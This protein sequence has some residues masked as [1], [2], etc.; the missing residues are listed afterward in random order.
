MEQCLVALL[1]F[2]NIVAAKTSSL[3]KKNTKTG[4]NRTNIPYTTHIHP[5]GL[6][7]LCFLFAIWSNAVYVC[8]SIC[9]ENIYGQTM[10][11]NK[12]HQWPW[13]AHKKNEYYYY[14]YSRNWN[15]KMKRRN[16]VCSA[17]ASYWNS[18]SCSENKIS[19]YIRAYLMNGRKSNN[20]NMTYTT[21]A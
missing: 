13:C 20:M 3:G 17:V 7:T 12:S 18:Y 5:T 19:I 8:S 21:H 10:P 6:T 15:G 11:K 4:K 14:Y 1:W 16:F 2:H 9:G